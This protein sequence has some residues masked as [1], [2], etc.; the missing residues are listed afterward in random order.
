MYVRFLLLFV[1]ELLGTGVFP[2]RLG[3][4]QI[5]RYVHAARSSKATLYPSIIH[6]IGY[7]HSRMIEMRNGRWLI[8]FAGSPS[9]YRYHSIRMS[10]SNCMSDRNKCSWCLQPT[11]ASMSAATDQD[12]E[13]YR[14]TQG[15]PVDECGLSLSDPPVSLMMIA[16]LSSEQIFHSLENFEP[17]NILSLF[18]SYLHFIK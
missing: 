11:Y 18:A 6:L 8:A 12:T 10:H 5:S 7:A 14:L 15:Q 9:Y 2:S 17:Q 13:V 1:A 16:T 4:E 3:G